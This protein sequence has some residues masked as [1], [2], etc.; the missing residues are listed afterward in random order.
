ML[1]NVVIGNEVVEEAKK[2][3]RRCLVFKV[4]YEKEYASVRRDFV[5]NRLDGLMTA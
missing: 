4:H 2:C 5:P 1:H 3:N